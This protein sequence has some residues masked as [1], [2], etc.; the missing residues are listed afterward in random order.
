ML[1]FSP[2]AS[3]AF[4][5]TGNPVSLLFLRAA[6][7]SSLSTVASEYVVVNMSNRDR[8]LTILVDEQ[9]RSLLIPSSRP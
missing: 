2:L 3:G 9:N 1:G 7:M 4:A 6:D 5:D 8:S